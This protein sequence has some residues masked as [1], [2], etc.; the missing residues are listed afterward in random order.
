[1]L[2]IACVHQNQEGSEAGADCMRVEL[3]K[4]LLLDQGCLFVQIGH[5]TQCE[6]THHRQE[7]ALHLREAH[8]FVVLLRPR[9]YDLNEYH[10]MH[11][12]GHTHR[13]QACQGLLLL[14]LKEELSDAE[15]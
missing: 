6:A 5:Q 8:S 1:M 10:Y 9:V 7:E 15:G 4:G 14:L 3:L 13:A 11:D 2:A 12:Q